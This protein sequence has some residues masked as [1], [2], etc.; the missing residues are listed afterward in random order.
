MTNDP[1]QTD[2]DSLAILTGFDHSLAKANHSGKAPH[3]V[4]K[5]ELEADLN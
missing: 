3:V 2:A 4:D 1:Y 5:Q